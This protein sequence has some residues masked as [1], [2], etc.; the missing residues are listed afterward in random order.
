MKC[1]FCSYADSKVTDSRTVENG[2]RRRRECQRC[3]LRFTTYERI[4][5]TALGRPPST[6][7]AAKSSTA[8]S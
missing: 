4:Q 5:T 6:T 7:T 3:S 1:P 2:I 8:R